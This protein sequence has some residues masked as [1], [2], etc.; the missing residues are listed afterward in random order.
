MQPDP[1]QRP[2]LLLFSYELRLLAKIC[3][4]AI[5]SEV[6]SKLQVI[7]KVVEV[8]SPSIA[9]LQQLKQQLKGFN[10]ET[11]PKQNSL[12]K[13]IQSVEGDYEG[14]IEAAKSKCVFEHEALG[15]LKLS[16]NYLLH[17]L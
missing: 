6:V 13:A 12:C 8:Q 16:V 5:E 1:S 7:P 15:L 17:T 4:K 14:N 10:G 2:H 9:H 11:D 3:Q